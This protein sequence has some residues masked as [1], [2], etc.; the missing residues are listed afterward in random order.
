MT[1]GTLPWQPILGSKLAKSDYSPLIVAL[2][3]RNGLQYRYSDLDDL[4]ILCVNLV[5]FS[6]VTPE[7]T[8]VKDVYP[9]VSFFKINLSDKLS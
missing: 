5:N 1:Q 9:V 3:F 7:F 6:P 2:A 4:A 8:K